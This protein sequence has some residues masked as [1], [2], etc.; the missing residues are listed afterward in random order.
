M[1]GPSSDLG[2]YV[3]GA[4]VNQFDR[5]TN[6]GM[7]KLDHGC[8][9]LVVTLSPTTTKLKWYHLHGALSDGGAVA[10]GAVGAAGASVQK[11][12]PLAPTANGPLAA[13]PCFPAAL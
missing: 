11:N 6:L 8:Q 9:F 1:A 3:F 5:V 2:P 7:R 10:V 13:L 12:T 4:C